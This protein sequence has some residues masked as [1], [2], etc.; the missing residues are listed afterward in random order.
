MLAF[1]RPPT[2]ATRGRRV[3][4]K[5]TVTPRK[6]VVTIVL[7]QKVRARWLTVGRRTVRS[8]RGRFSSSFVPAFR[9]SYRYYTVAKADLDTD[10]GATDF[11]PLRVR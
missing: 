2:R 10:R 3:A 6:R 9:A 5:G 1:T 4:V 11:V 7:Q 8:R